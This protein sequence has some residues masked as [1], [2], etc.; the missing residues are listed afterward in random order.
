MSWKKSSLSLLLIFAWGLTACHA[1]DENSSQI[2]LAQP[3]SKFLGQVQAQAHSVLP[4]I[5]L[6]HSIQSHTFWPVPTYWVQPNNPAYLTNF[7]HPEAACNWMGV[8]GQVFDAQGNPVPNITVKL[9]GTLNGAAVS[10]LGMTGT[11]KIYGPAAYEIVLGGQAI[12]SQASL[13]V[14]LLDGNSKA[15]SMPATI[16]TFQDCQKNLILV[17]FYEVPDPRQYLLPVV[18]N[19][20]PSN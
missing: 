13:V 16:D 10:Q 5:P 19:T 12:D 18:F 9:S 6:P 2:S 20:D 1:V 11:S 14:Q 17:N 7:A 4:S 3:V 8:S 15:I